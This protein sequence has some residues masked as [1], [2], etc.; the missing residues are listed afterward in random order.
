VPA[1]GATFDDETLITF[2]AVKNSEDCP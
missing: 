1:A 2:E